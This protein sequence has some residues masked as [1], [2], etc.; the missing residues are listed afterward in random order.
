M[1]EG[2]KIG[3]GYYKY[4]FYDGYFF[5][6]LKHGDGKLEHRDGIIYTG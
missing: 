1:D 3:K 2:L 5:N 4:I 6:D